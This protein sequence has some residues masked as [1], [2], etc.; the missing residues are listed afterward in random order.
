MKPAKEA[1]IRALIIAVVFVLCGAG[2]LFAITNKAAKVARLAPVAWQSYNKEI[3][4]GAMI[5]GKNESIPI[6]EIPLVLH[7]LPPMGKDERLLMCFANPKDPESVIA[8]V[9]V[10]SKQGKVKLGDIFK[11]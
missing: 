3:L 6:V 11:R 7:K 10:F 9:V 5:V 4:A 1:L 2:L 8:V